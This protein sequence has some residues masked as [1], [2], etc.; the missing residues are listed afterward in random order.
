MNHIIIIRK[1]GVVVAQHVF[2]DYAEAVTWMSQFPVDPDDR[3]KMSAWTWEY[4]TKPILRTY[5]LEVNRFPQ[6]WDR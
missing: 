6:R 1:L 2:P 3:P 4:Q 5:D